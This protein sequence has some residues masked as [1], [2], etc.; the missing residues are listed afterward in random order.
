[1]NMDITSLQNP[2]IKHIVKL[3]ESKRQRQ[4]DGLMIVEGVDELTLAL[5]AGLVPDALLH[6][7]EVS[8]SAPTFSAPLAVSTATRAV[9]EKISYRDNPDGWLGVFPIPQTAF[10]DLRLSPAPLIL[11]A[12]SVEKPGNLGAILRTADAAGVDAVIV[13]DPRVDVWNPNVVRASRGALFTVQVVQTDNAAALAWLRENQIRILAATPSA[14][15]DYSAV[16]MREPVAIAVGTEDEGL[17]DFWMSQADLRV[18]I[19]MSG[20]VNSLNV[21]IAAALITYEAIRQ[22]KHS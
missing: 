17:T 9:F 18:K 21:S 10:A 22:R 6:A 3:R 1:M 4:Q 15:L 2:K 5:G 11:L 7:P 12:E 20:K 19:P 14:K 8:S 13:A 16:N